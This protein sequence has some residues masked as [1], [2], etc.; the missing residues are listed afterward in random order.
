[1]PCTNG[2]AELQP[3]R[4]SLYIFLDTITAF[5]WQTNSVFDAAT[6]C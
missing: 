3:T 4:L 6:Q 5:G 1:M 2:L